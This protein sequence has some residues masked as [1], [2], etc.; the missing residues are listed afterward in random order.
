M[1][2]TRSFLW[3]TSSR[4]HTTT[5]V[6]QQD[7]R[8]CPPMQTRAGIHKTLLL[9]PVLGVPSDI[10]G[11]LVPASKESVS[12]VESF[13][14]QQSSSSSI[15]TWKA[16]GSVLVTIIKAGPTT[17]IVWDQSSGTCFIAAPCGALGAGCP[18]GTAFLAQIVMDRNRVLSQHS[19]RSGSADNNSDEEQGANSL[20]SVLRDDEDMYSWN[21]SILLMDVIS[22]GRVRNFLAEPCSAHDRYKLLMEVEDPSNGIIVS[23][24]MRR[25]WAGNLD[26]L[27]EFHTEH[28]AD[29]PH[30]IDCYVQLGD[31]PLDMR[32][33][34]AGG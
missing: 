18:V 3:D 23:Q 26:A 2:P 32:L 14:T 21:V 33:V 29:L 20:A 25:Q 5:T 34:R 10:Q 1:P 11:L 28:G 19:P 4:Q 12:S 30:V 24:C 22:L 16:R 9:S 7:P 17:T 13:R 8:Y 15:F 31:S 6:Q 27:M